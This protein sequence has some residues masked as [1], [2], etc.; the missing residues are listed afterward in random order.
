M[1]GAMAKAIPEFPLVA[2]IRVSPG[3]ISPRAS[4][5]LIIESAGRSFTEPKEILWNIDRLADGA[6][7]T[8]GQSSLRG[9]SLI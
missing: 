6:F 3:W 4:V 5:L 9:T 8:G 2:S 7:C 1:A